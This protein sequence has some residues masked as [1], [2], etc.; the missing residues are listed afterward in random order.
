MFQFILT[1]VGFGDGFAR[2]CHFR[3]HARKIAL[4]LVQFT[5][6]I[7]EQ[8][9]GVQALLIE[10]A[11]HRYF[12]IEQVDR[13]AQCGFLLLELGQFGIALL[14]LDFEDFTLTAI[15]IGLDPID[16]LLIL[17]QFR[18][19]VYQK[20]KIGFTRFCKCAITF[21]FKT[22]ARQF[23]FGLRQFCLR[24]LGF[25]AH[26]NLI[27]LDQITVTYHD[28]GNDPAFK[29]LDLVDRTGRHHLPEGGCRFLDLSGC[30]PRDQGDET[31][32]KHDHCRTDKDGNPAFF[33]QYSM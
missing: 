7:Q 24:C 3:N 4:R 19:P 18:I 27:F 12:L 15:K 30:R 5:L 33:Q 22:Q 28:F 32:R 10:R 29:M 8:H 26:Q 14:D 1:Q 17:C 23:G 16:F 9:L 2:T 20:G 11:T 6:D 25:Q 31:D 21:G 13:T